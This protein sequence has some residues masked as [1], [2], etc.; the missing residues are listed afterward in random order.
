MSDGRAGAALPAWLAACTPTPPPVLVER[1]RVIMQSR[2]ADGR[3]PGPDDYL[4]AADDLLHRL[5]HDGCTSRTSAVDLLVVDA[6]VTYA[7]EIASD[8]P[9][10][11][12]ARAT[13]A[14]RRIAA[15]A[16]PHDAERHPSAR[17]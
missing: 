1:V 8:E 6:L 10:R 11:V 14:M 9:S 3:A 7:F 2:L 12:A 13:D 16:G 17:S 5:L 15:L 4:G